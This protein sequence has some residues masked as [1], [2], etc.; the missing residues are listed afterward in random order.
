MEYSRFAKPKRKMGRW[1]SVSESG[2]RKTIFIN[3]Q[4]WKICIYDGE[5]VFD[6]CRMSR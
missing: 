6:V 4:I 5:N 3:R 1:H 2:I